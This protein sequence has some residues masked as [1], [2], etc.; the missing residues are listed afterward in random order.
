[1]ELGTSPIA[2]HCK[3]I[4][5][6]VRPGSWCGFAQEMGV[7][8]GVVLITYNILNLK[9]AGLTLILVLTTLCV[10]EIE[11]TLEHVLFRSIPTT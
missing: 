6:V 5:S 2:W 9:K 3:A 10:T 4:A 7:T 11:V 8:L 1:M